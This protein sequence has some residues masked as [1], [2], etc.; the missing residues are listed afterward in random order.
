MSD[1]YYE[2]SKAARTYARWL[3]AQALHGTEGLDALHIFK[4][5]RG[6][7]AVTKAAV[8]SHTS[9]D[10]F[11]GLSKL[12][13]QVVD[14]RTARGRLALREAPLNT[15]VPRRTNRVTASWALGGYPLAFAKYN[16]DDP[17]MYPG[18]YGFLKGFQDSL[19]RLPEE[20][21]VNYIISAA[22]ADMSYSDDELFLSDSAALSSEE[23]SAGILNGVVESGDGSPA[24]LATDMEAL[25]TDCRDGDSDRPH[26]ILSARGGQYLA[27]RRVDGTPEFPNVGPLGGSINGVPVL[28]SRSAGNRLIL[29]DADAIVE[30]DGGLE[31]ERSTQAAVQ[32]DSAPTTNSATATHTQLVSAFQTGLVVMKFVR[33]SSWL[34][35]EDDAV[36]FISLDFD[37][38]PN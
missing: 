24:S 23:T 10:V 7:D 27:S 9:S 28:I 37:H 33:Y 30:N 15:R 35:L 25:W 5:M 38:S 1:N 8:T 16:F 34:K 12:F 4:Q 29:V 17:S 20:Q 32:Q 13:L 21:A 22:T 6:V 31:V 18:K 19:L 14:K 11:A 2:I 26:Y 36:S 3:L